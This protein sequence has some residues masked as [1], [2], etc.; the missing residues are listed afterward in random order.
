MTELNREA[1]IHHRRPLVC[2]DQLACRRAR[3]KR[4]KKLK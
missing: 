3:R 2:F 4:E 1:T